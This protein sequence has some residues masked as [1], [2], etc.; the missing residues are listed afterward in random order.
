[1]ERDRMPG[2]FFGPATFVEL[3]RHRAIHQPDLRVFTYLVDGESQE[4]HLAAGELDRQARAIGALLAAERMA[5]ERALLLYPP[6][7]EFIAGFFGCLYAATIAV[8]AFPPRR[9][10]SLERI[11]AIAAD[12]EAQAALTTTAIYERIGPMLDELPQ[13]KRLRWHLTDQLSPDL[14]TGWH[15]PTVHTDTVAFL[16]YTSGST[17]RPKGVVLTHGNLLHN[18]AAIHHLFEHTRSG[19]GVYWLPSYHDMGL[20]GG[21]LQP[22]YAGRPNVFMSPMAFLQKP[23]RWLQAISRYR[24]TTSGAPN[25]AYELCLRKTTDEELRELDLSSW[26]VAFNGAEPV[27]AETLRAFAERFAPCGFRPE[28]FYP[29]YGLAEGTLIVTGGYVQRRPLVLGFDAAALEH[30]RTQLADEE[31]A[32][33]RELVSS[34]EAIPDQT[35]LI[36]D[37][38]TLTPVAE[39]HIGEIWAAGPSIAQGYWQRPD[40]QGRTFGNYLADGTGPYLRTGDLGFFAQGELF[41]TGRL[42]DLIIVRGLNHYPQDIEQSAELAHAALRQGA[43]AAFDVPENGSQRLVL[44][45]EV[46]RTRRQDAPAAADAV[47]HAVAREHELMLDAIVL[48]KPGSIPKTSS[49][50]IQRHACRAAYLAGELDAFYQWSRLDEEESPLA[51]PERAAAARKA[52][53]GAAEPIKRPQVEPMQAAA[54]PS[55]AGETTQHAAHG[56]ATNGHAHKPHANGHALNGEVHAAKAGTSDEEISDRVFVVL[57]E[58]LGDR[59]RELTLGMQLADLGIDSLERVQLLAKVEERFERRFPEDIAGQLETVSEV[60]TAVHEHLLSQPARAARSVADLPE[61]CYRFELS[62]EYQALRED[63]GLLDSLGMGNPYF[64]PHER[65]TN[66]TTVVGGRELINF[67]SYN[68]LGM[69]GDPRVAQAAKAAIDRY[70]TSVSASRL[71]SG[72]KPLHRQLEQAIAEFVGVEDAIVLVGGHAT[73]ETVIGHLFGAPDLVVHDAL[74]HNSIVQGCKLSG[75]KR[76][77]FPHN[78]WR[79]LDKLLADVR[80]EYRRVLVAIEGA[81]SMDGDIAPLPEFVEVKRRHKAYLLVDEAHSAGTLGATGRGAGEHFGV[82]PGN[83]DFWMGTLSKSY[84]SCGGYIAGSRAVVEYLKYTA[85]GF[86]FSVGMTPPNAAAAL[87]SLRIL[88][89]EPQR[90]ATLR[91]NARLFLELARARG[92]NTGLSDG[93]P[94]VPVI[95]GNSVLALRLSHALR[96]RGIN[97]Q[98]IVYPAVE[99]SAARLRFFLTSLH[100]EHQIR[101]T[102]AAVAE[103]LARLTGDGETAPESEISAP[104]LSHLRAAEASRN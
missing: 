39:G 49:G 50:K 28:A 90:V 24:G 99:E 41:V 93:T 58:L 102:V 9:N 32:S 20:I 55:A 59:A 85:P 54:T 18:S 60:I 3:V 22:L 94:I 104:N 103:E 76:R 21:I 30:R 31:S 46:E 97:V 16:Q 1:M 86:V 37:P 87:E 12:S 79:A 74:A 11:Q 100:R 48:L 63:L 65:V 70:G 38:E 44:A 40:E 77:S 89:R 71:V 35:V 45:I 42:K 64:N 88:A 2:S 75:A 80:G 51:T 19:S 13:L 36:V 4:Q 73:N 69:S 95:V 33:I 61:S 26:R 92:L 14:A 34:G 15:V 7:L 98:P 56:R 29:C 81:Y 52:Q 72:E 78:D 91:D 68:Y 66:D 10:R 84:G 62:P 96:G 83:V 101:A 23:V 17:A 67:S 8:T 47:R 82:D 43:A 27:R 57:R 6:G 53:A 25:F 5:G